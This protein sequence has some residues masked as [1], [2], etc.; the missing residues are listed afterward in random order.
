MV[1]FVKYLQASSHVHTQLKLFGL[2]QYNR[3]TFEKL[4]DIPVYF[5]PTK[6]CVC[7]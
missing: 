4:K 5:F 3:W 1:I 7:D 6:D 2:I